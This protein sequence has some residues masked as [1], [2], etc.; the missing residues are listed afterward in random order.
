MRFMIIR[1]ADRETEAGVDALRLG[2]ILA[3]LVPAEPE[4]HGLIA[5]MEIQASR[6]PARVTASGEPILL[7]DQNRARWDHLLIRRGHSNPTPPTGHGSPRC[8]VSSPGSRPRRSSS[9]I[10]R[11]RSGWPPARRPRSRWLTRFDRSPR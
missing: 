10:A 4:V 9:S 3:E 7:L 6:A 11:S 1:K 8:M 5:L 2:R